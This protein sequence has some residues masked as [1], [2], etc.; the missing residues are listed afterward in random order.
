MGVCSRQIASAKRL[1]TKHGQ[2]VIWY[3]QVNG[4]PVDPDE[5]WKPGSASTTEY[6]PKIAFFPTE[7]INREFGRMVTGTWEPTGNVGGIMAAQ[8]FEPVINDYILRDSENYKLKSFIPIN[9]NGEIICYLLEF[10]R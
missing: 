7:L 10:V 5:P 9:P 3:S 2:T 6:L 8:S 1:V 4:T